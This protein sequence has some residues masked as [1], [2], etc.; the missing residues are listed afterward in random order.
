MSNQSA[1]RL[2]A[3]VFARYMRRFAK[4]DMKSDETAAAVNIRTVS[5]DVVDVNAGYPTPASDNGPWG[6]TPIQAWMFE[7]GSKHPLF[8]NE[9]HWYNQPKRPILDKTAEVAGN[10]AETVY[11][12]VRIAELAREFGYH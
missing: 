3:N 4:S 8:G 9:R 6:W 5:S 7:T 1:L 12:D 10:E 2:A 11:A